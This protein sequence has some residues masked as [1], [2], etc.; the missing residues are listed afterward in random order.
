MITRALIGLPVRE[1]HRYL[2]PPCGYEVVQIFTLPKG[3]RER[4]IYAKNQN[5]K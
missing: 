5:V 2:G 3:R 1:H 4:E